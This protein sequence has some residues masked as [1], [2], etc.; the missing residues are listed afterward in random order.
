MAVERNLFLRSEK[1][2]FTIVTAVYNGART[3]EATISS[4]DRQSFRDFEYIVLDGASTDSTV[5]ILE[6]NS[7]RIDYWR[8]EPDSGI[9]NAWNKALGM[10][11]GDWIA[12][13]GADDLYYDNALQEYARAI[14]AFPDASIQYVSSRVHLLKDRRIVR[15][16]GSAWEWP[17][18]SRF[19]T[20][21]HVGSMH[22]RSLF[23][24]LGNFDESYRL[25]GDYELLLRPRNLLRA[26]FLD[27]VTAGMALGG[28][29]NADVRPALVEQER[30]KRTTGGRSSWLCALERRKALFKNTIRS[31]VWY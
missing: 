21:A 20:V 14:T 28:V 10:A 18:F 29:S 25:S 22:H 23:T 24:E 1:P 16:I 12:F 8:S 2:L 30:A 31:L 15:T 19:M 3:L 26:V 13:L 6:S 7:H 11:R 27:R 9:Y 17:A 4:I 5:S